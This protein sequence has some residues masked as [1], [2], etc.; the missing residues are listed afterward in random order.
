MSDI[1]KISSST[2]Q[3]IM[4]LSNNEKHKHQELLQTYGKEYDEIL[5][6]KQI[7]FEQ[8]LIIQRM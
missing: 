4:M 2:E 7:E 5:E 3:H 8:R 6:I 1:Q